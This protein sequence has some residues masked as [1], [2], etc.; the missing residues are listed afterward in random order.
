MAPM[1]PVQD[2]RYWLI[3]REQN[4][5]LVIIILLRGANVCVFKALQVYGK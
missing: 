4:C 2:F 3:T 1:V 5:E